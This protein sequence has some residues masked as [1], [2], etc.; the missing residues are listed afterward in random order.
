MARLHL[1]IAV[2]CICFFI[3]STNRYFV[4]QNEEHSRKGE[5]ESGQTPLINSAYFQCDQK[6]TCTHVV[7]FKETNKFGIILGHDQ[8]ANIEEKISV[9]KKQ[10]GKDMLVK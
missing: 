4:L 6:A 9:W 7:K 8:L 1:S 3:G 10:E 5:D 2:I